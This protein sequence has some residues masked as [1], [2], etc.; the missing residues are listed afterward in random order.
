MSS[1]AQHLVKWPTMPVDGEQQMAINRLIVGIAA[2]AFNI[3]LLP[4]SV[5]GWEAASA[6]VAY[7]GFGSLIVMH[8]LRYPDA[9]PMRRVVALMVDC[10]AASYE[11]HIGGS[12]T[13][14]QF[15][16]YLWIVFGNGFRFGASALRLSMIVAL[17]GFSL[18]VLT[19]S[20]WRDHPAEVVGGFISLTIVPFYA[21]TLIKRLSEAR[22][23]AELASQAKSLFLTSVSH[24]LRTP[25]NAIIGMATLLDQ[26]D[27]KADQMRMSQTIMTSARS[28]LSMIDGVLDIARIETGRTEL[29][30]KDFD[31]ATLIGDIRT[32]FLLPCTVK[33][34]AFNVHVTARTPLLLYGDGRKLH[35][36]VVNLVGNALKFTEHGHI[37]IGIDCLEERDETILLH[38]QVADSGRGIELQE[39]PRVFE[40][41]SQANATV[42][43]RFGGIGLGLTLVRNNVTLLGGTVHVESQVGHG[44][45]FSFCVP[46]G[47]QE[48][49]HS[50]VPDAPRLRAFIVSTGA[51]SIHPLL[52]LLVQQGVDIRSESIRTTTMQ[53][54]HLFGVLAF[55]AVDPTRIDDSIHTIDRLAFV[56]LSD[57]KEGGLPPLLLQRQFLT[58]LSNDPTKE[59]LARFLDRVA[60]LCR[61]VAPPYGQER[62]PH[63]E[64]QFRVLIADDNATN[65]SVLQMILSAGGHVVTV[66][67]DGK[68][69]LAALAETRFDV[70]IFDVNMREMDGIAAAKA[71]HRAAQGADIVPIIGLTA[72]AT[73]ST[74]EQCLDAGMVLCMVKP[75]E[76]MVLLELVKQVVDESCPSRIGVYLAKDGAKTEENPNFGSST[77]MPPAIKA[78][79][80]RG[81]RNLG[82]DTFLHDLIVTFQSEIKDNF[83]HLQQVS[84]EGD[85]LGFRACAHA[86]RSISANIGAHHLAEICS[87][88]QTISTA[89]LK[90]NSR[91]WVENIGNEINRVNAS[92]ATIVYN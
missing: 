21:L 15:A 81:L 79:I 29:V 59:A 4:H 39:Q 85:V 12:A 9:C 88:C 11:L 14:W 37:T 82:G 74:R 71:Y 62:L 33:G 30:P 66:A 54:P 77:T 72:D 84:A 38:V 57:D 2:I 34:L 56:G 24:E 3:W 83:Q 70:A 31:L 67:N 18:M 35:D 78:E 36:V 44:S 28:L 43:E 19:T 32:I 48:P 41:F 86:L 68:E 73:P 13:M 55:A 90:D 27:L 7:L 92:L 1:L 58:I 80:I 61:I 91:I 16:G 17:G 52:D 20:Y 5:G 49:D 47:R 53:E 65:R 25:L 75:I 46:F 50:A 76:P 45:V 42:H 23:A 22:E 40:M 63:S 26:S 6:A 89:D 64:H 8:L 51:N 60:G 87:P 10:G 69:A